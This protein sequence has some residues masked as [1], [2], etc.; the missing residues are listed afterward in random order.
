MAPPA[1]PPLFLMSATSPSICCS[2]SANEGHAPH[3]LARGA[4]RGEE[5]VGERVVGGEEGGGAV[6]E[7]DDRR[8]GEGGEIDQLGGA[9]AGGVDQAVG[10]DEAAFGVG[11]E[12]LHGDAVHAAEDVAG[13]EG[14]AGDH[15]LRGADRGLDD[16]AD[17][18]GAQGGHG[19]EDGGAAGHVALH[20]EHA[21]V[22]LDRIAAGVEGDGLADET[23]D[24][25]RSPVAPSGS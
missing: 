10:E 7:G 25:D 3:A 12:D 5:P 23:R 20:V 6:A 11:G 14:V 24:A 4:G 21:L 16:V 15:V 1:R 9:A 13:A 8:A 18:E 2:S 22:G 17:T 19:A